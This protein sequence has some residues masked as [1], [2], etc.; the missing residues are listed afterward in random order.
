MDRN[1]E[2]TRP[3]TL[4]PIER[5]RCAKSAESPCAFRDEEGYCTK[6]YTTCPHKLRVAKKIQR[7]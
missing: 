6:K 5:V 7:K 4:P 2:K 1:D 3:I